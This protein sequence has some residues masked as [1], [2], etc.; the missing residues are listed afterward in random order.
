MNLRY[1]APV[2]K[3]YSV[4]TSIV[5][6]GIIL[7]VVAGACLFAYFTKGFKIACDG[8]TWSTSVHTDGNNLRQPSSSCWPTIIFAGQTFNTPNATFSYSAATRANVSFS[9]AYM[10][11]SCTV[12]PGSSMTVYGPNVS[13]GGTI[14][15]G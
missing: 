14:F 1:S 2:Q 8:F 4:R 5:S 3:E 6:Y 11:S 7:L 15:Q 12:E 10:S 9:G 13:G